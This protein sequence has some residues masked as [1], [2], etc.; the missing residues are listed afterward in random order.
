MDKEKIEKAL[1]WA[2]DKAVNGHGKV[3]KKIIP[4]VQ[5]FVKGF[6]ADY[7][8]DVDAQVDSLI[9][10]QTAKATTSGFTT[11]FGGIITLPVSIPVNIAS[12]LYIQVRM[13]TAIAHM[14]GHDVKSD[15]V[16]T[17]VYMCLV[18]M[19]ITD[20]VKQTVI[21]I[22]KKPA[23]NAIKNISGKTLQ[24]I[25]KKVG[26]KL[27]TKFGQKGIVSLGKAIPVLGGLVGG[28]VDLVATKKIGE[29]AKKVFKPKRKTA[30][31]C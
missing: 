21:K 20:A 26:M 28:G 22:G 5:D 16:Q 29:F 10:R 11:S 1:F 3:S 13:I 8:D 24:E 30:K 31:K 19:P 18:K 6:Q 25:N 14:Y 17:M 23:V 7:P 4:S 2:Y 15:K 9:R 27:L 12:I